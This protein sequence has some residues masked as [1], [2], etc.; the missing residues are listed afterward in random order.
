MGP[1]EVRPAE[2]VL[3]STAMLIMGER[4]SGALG[5][6]Q[7]PGGSR[8]SK[9]QRLY[10]TR[11]GWTS[12]GSGGVCREQRDYSIGPDRRC[13]WSAIPAGH[14]MDASG[15]AGVTYME[16][17]YSPG[18]PKSH[19]IG[20]AST[21]NLSEWLRSRWSVVG[22]RGLPL[23]PPSLP[24]NRNGHPSRQLWASAHVPPSRLQ[25]SSTPSYLF[26]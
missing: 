15:S 24:R 26:E 25:R 10:S 20:Y 2:A 1:R 17:L 3:V 18:P 6:I 4:S 13:G 16:N 8:G 9:A 23:P 14:E 7:E 21:H 22:A 11:M 19:R 12:Y 5:G